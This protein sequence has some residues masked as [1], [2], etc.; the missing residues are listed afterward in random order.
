MGKVVDGFGVG[1]SGVGVEE[2]AAGMVV[3]WEAMVG[4]DGADG[5]AGG[6]AL[7]GLKCGVILER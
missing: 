5:S 1:S 2:I 3:S 7:P 6:L 4:S